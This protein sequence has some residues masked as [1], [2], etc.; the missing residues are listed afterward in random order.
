MFISA[1]RPTFGPATEYRSPVNKKF[2]IIYFQ[3][4]FKIR[5]FHRAETLMK[6]SCL[7]KP[8]PTPYTMLS[9]ELD[10]AAAKADKL[11]AQCAHTMTLGEWGG[12]VS[13][14]V[15]VRVHLWVSCCCLTQLNFNRLFS[16]HRTFQI[17]LFIWLTEF[18]LLTSS[19]KQGICLHTWFWWSE[20]ECRQ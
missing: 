12:V 19:S 1:L 5:L 6:C 4:P 3:P 20:T 7:W 10:S 15:V 18:Q 13:R 14:A 8:Y 2:D 9:N 17:A 16:N 11:P